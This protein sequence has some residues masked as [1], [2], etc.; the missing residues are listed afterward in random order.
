MDVDVARRLLEAEI[1]TDGDESTLDYMAEMIAAE[2]AALTT[3]SAVDLLSPF[4]I[5]MGAVEENDVAEALCRRIAAKVKA[6]TGTGGGGGAD[7]QK[8][9][10]KKNDDASGSAD[11]RSH[12]TSLMKK[13]QSE[14]YDDPYLGLK[15][16]EV[17]V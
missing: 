1:G 7:A 4:L 10:E 2:G 15:S 9:D 14:S 8:E 3:E 5:E 13:D 11:D 17:N 16:S 6:A 12:L